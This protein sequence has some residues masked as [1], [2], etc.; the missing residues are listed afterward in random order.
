MTEVYIVRHGQ[1]EN[2]Q[3]NSSLTETGRKQAE[4]TGVYLSNHGF[5]SVYSSP[6]RRTQETAQIIADILKISVI[7]DLRL[8]ERLVWGEREGESYE[9]FLEQWGKT[10]RERYYQ[11]PYGDSSFASGSRLKQALDDLTKIKKPSLIVAHS[12]V[13]GDFLRNTFSDRLFPFYTVPTANCRD[14]KIANCSIT[15]VEVKDRTYSLKQVNNTLITL[16]IFQFNN[17][18]YLL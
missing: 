4:I 1:R 17:L 9:E 14:V 15:I 18:S 5:A 7:T 13:I 10:S 2:H 12:G 11:P 3:E 6:L 8:R 16:T